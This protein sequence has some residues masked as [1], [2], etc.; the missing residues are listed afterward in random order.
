MNWYKKSQQQSFDFLKGLNLRQIPIEETSEY[1][2]LI[3]KN[4][5]LLRKLIDSCQSFQ[6]AINALKTYGFKF[7]IIKDI[8]SVEIENKIYII[9]DIPEIKDPYDWIWS[10]NDWNLDNY[11]DS[12]NYN[13]EFWEYPQ[14]VYHATTEEKWSQIQ[15]IGLKVKD[16]SRGIDNRSTGAA[17]FTSDNPDDIEPYGNVVIEINTPKMKA[18]GYMP[19]VSKEGPI[20]TAEQREALAHM[21]GLD[22]FYV[23]I[24]DAGIRPNTIIFFKN[25]PAQ[26]LRRIG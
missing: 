1:Q 4:I 5:Q 15:L 25:I 23:E 21:I 14:I 8:I 20:I 16:E 18:D 6:E 12:Q 9:N 17:I 2:N 10:I 7:K 24:G 26:Y 22:D 11:V 19:E 13:E 3:Q